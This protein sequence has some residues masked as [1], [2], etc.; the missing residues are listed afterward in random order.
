MWAEGIWRQKRV[1]ETAS[2]ALLSRVGWQLGWTIIKHLRVVL[3]YDS[4][5]FASPETEKDG[6]QLYSQLYRG[7]EFHS[8]CQALP[9]FHS[10]RGRD[11]DSNY[12]LAAAGKFAKQMCGYSA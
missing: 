9:V 12:N 3:Y 10:S 2:A 1:T 8:V 5:Y 7:L 4:S 11:A 6:S